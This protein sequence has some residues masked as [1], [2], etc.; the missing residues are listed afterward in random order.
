MAIQRLIRW[1]AF[2]WLL[3][4]AT[5]I[6]SIVFVPSDYVANAVLSSLWIPIG[7]LRAI[8]HMLF[9]IGLIGFYLVQADKAGRLGSIGFVLS[10]F[11]MLML[12]V[13]MVVSTWILPVI[14]AQPNAPKTAFEM[15]DPSGPLSA[16]S[17]VIFG[18]SVVAG[19]GLIILGLVTMRA[20]V[21]PRWAGLLL[22]IAIFL[23]FAVV[24]GA[25]GEWIVKFGDVLFSVAEVWLA[26]AMLQKLKASS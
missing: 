18:G 1:S 6:V 25:A 11:G 5:G 16:F 14:A 3:S 7:A 21:L 9:M 12:S 13:Q 4:A 17:R 15:L 24:A 8:S 10:F 23:D 26:Y 2:A 22:A 20:R 19:F